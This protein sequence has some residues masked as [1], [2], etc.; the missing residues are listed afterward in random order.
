[1]ANPN[2]T[3][4][5]SSKDKPALQLTSYQ[6]VMA[7]CALLLLMC[8]L[9]VAGILVQRF[10]EGGQASRVASNESPAPAARTATRPESAPRQTEGVQIAPRPVVLPT[11]TG[12]T[13]AAPGNTVN[14]RESGAKYVPAPPPRRDSAKKETT[15][16]V[17]TAPPADK[18]APESK[19]AAPPPVA[20]PGV[21]SV[22]VEPKPPAVPDQPAQPPAELEANASEA[23]AGAVSPP[24][25]APDTAAGPYTIQVTSF[26][27]G[28]LDRA[29]R[30]KKE[31]EEKTD[32][33]VNLVPSA[34]G[35]HVRGFVGEY[36]DR[37]TADQARDA[38]RKI[39]GFEDCFVKSLGEE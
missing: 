26:D 33:T 2:R 32:F 24:K 19:A 8:A 23:P 17:N 29:K 11:E 6:L 25:P 34:D 3:R 20:D 37:G 10:T 1:M 16:A 35:K 4:A 36:A 22:P 13:G 28:N 12:K 30:F 18:P 31:T 7:I 27:S 9:F 21:P 14:E 15:P 39:K 38:M 5:K